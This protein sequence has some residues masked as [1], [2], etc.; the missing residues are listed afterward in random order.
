VSYDVARDAGLGDFRTDLLWWKTVALLDNNDHSSFPMRQFGVRCQQAARLLWPDPAHPGQS[1]YEQDIA[2]VLTSRGVPINGVADFRTL[3]PPAI[4]PVIPASSANFASNHPTS[5][6]ADY[7]SANAMIVTYAT[8]GPSVAYVSYQLYKHSKYGPCDRLRFTDGTFTIGTDDVY[9]ND[10]TMVVS[11]H[12]RQLGNLS[13]FVP[14]NTVT[15]DLWRARCQSEGTIDAAGLSGAY[16][17]DVKPFGFI[18]TKATPNGFSVRVTR[19]GDVLSADRR[20]DRVRYRLDIE[21]PSLS[22]PSPLGRNASYAWTFTEFDGASVARNGRQVVYAAMKDQPF[23]M[24]IT[25]TRPPVNAGD[26][27]RTDT[28]TLRERGTDLDRPG[29][30][31]GSG[32]GDAMTTGF[33]F[34]AGAGTIAT[35]PGYALVYN[36]TTLATPPYC[37]ADFDDNGILGVQDIFAYLNAWFGGDPR[38]DI[39]DNGLSVQDIFTFLNT[40]FSGC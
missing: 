29:I 27:V 21:D 12:D 25:R 22:L 14:G 18:V 37:I 40:W 4:G 20:S 26:P 6:P 10:G 8:P 34:A 33:E 32:G 19:L 39:D 1:I 28:L 17:E 24:S 35:A 7:N 16:W 3:L 30:A 36:G 13:V 9:N 15:A 31:P 11:M 23:T 5:Q 2:D 38:A